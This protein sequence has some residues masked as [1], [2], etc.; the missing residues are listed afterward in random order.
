MVDCSE[1]DVYFRELHFRTIFLCCVCGIVVPLVIVSQLS[2]WLIPRRLENGN[3]SLP[4]VGIV[5]KAVN[6]QLPYGVNVVALA[7][8]R[9]SIGGVYVETP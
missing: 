9:R 2:N 7:R 4:V 6:F 5:G 1:I 8:N 3:Q